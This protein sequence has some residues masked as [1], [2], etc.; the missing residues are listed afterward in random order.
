MANL[1]NENVQIWTI[2]IF[3]MCH[4]CICDDHKLINKQIFYKNMTT[5]NKNS[6]IDSDFLRNN[7]NINIIVNE[8][9]TMQQK[10]DYKKRKRS[11]LSDTAIHTMKENLNDTELII[12]NNTK[13][14]TN[15]ILPEL[16]DKEIGNRTVEEFGKVILDSEED[17]LSTTT[18]YY[19]ENYTEPC[20]GD[21]EY[22]NLTK[23]EYIK[24]LH[25]YIYPRTFEWI[26]IGIH[27]VVF[28]IGLI[29]N[30]LVCIAVYRNHSMRTVTNYFIV[31]LAV[32]DFMVILICLPPTVLWDV[33]ETWFFG[34]AMCRIVLY[35]QVS[36]YPYL[37]LFLY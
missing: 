10:I 5:Q 21:V 17:Y 7:V 27:A 24:M 1:N 32:A 23:E 9:E 11:V 19:D 22:C 35:F 4:L 14:K 8:L 2:F 12:L 30:A 28:I 36:I 31:N 34:T 18:E 29:G 13:A 33:T 25:D 16:D 15:I 26:L 6:L 20:V 37:L 3:L